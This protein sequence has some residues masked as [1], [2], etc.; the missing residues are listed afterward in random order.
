MGNLGFSLVAAALSCFLGALFI[1]KAIPPNRRFGLVTPRT[2][3]D[4]SA[5]YRAHRALGCVF[6]VIGIVV[7]LLCQW[8]TTPVH[9]A[10]GLAGIALV[11]LAFAFVYCRYAA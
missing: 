10:S 9:P 7:G 2:L 11:V 3:G 5:W 6:L 8:P 1:L 4:P